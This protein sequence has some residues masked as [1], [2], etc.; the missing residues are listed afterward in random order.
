MKIVYLALVPAAFL[1][2]PA[3]AQSLHD[4]HERIWS[5]AGKSHAVTWRMRDRP[6]RVA[7]VHHQAGK[8]MMPARHHPQPQ[9]ARAEA[10]RSPVTQQTVGSD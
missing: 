5:P 10:P 3:A 2:A 7:H 1:A 8:G 4:T 6:E 9:Q